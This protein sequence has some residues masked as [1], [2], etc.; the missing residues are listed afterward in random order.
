[1][2]NKNAFRFRK[3][4]TLQN[5]LVENVKISLV[6]RVHSALAGPE[7]SLRTFGC[8]AAIPCGNPCTHSTNCLP[9]DPECACVYKK[10]QI[11]AANT[12]AGHVF[13]SCG[14]DSSLKRFRSVPGGSAAF[15]VN[16]K[17]PSRLSLHLSSASCCSPFLSI[18]RT[19]FHP[20]SLSSH[21]SHPLA[22]QVIH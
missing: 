16:V 1:M 7:Q 17:P 8:S 14:L 19:F 2:Q 15:D 9:H 21:H 13:S 3:I 11:K 6:Q 12:C 10:L 18:H 20:S 5:C 22:Q 4:C